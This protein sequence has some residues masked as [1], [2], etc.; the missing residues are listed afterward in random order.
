[1]TKLRTMATNVLYIALPVAYLIIEA[2]GR[3]HP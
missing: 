3:R 1:M 2:A